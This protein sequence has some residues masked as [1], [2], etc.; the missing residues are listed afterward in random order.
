MVDLQDMTVVFVVVLL[1]FSSTKGELFGVLYLYRLNQFPT[2]LV[3]AIQSSNAYMLN[4]TYYRCLE[5][6]LQYR[7]KVNCVHLWLF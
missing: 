3:H 1:L 5:A 7:I 4:I 6:K 2:Q